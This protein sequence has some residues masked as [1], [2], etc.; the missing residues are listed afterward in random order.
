VWFDPADPHGDAD[1]NGNGKP[2]KAAPRHRPPAEK[3]S[4]SDP[5]P[6]VPTDSENTDEVAQQGTSEEGGGRSRSTRSGA[7]KAST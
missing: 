3:A 6:N 7:G 4:A 1:G 2:A 5:A